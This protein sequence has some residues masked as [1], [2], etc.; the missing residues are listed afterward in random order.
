[1]ERPF[2]YSIF[3]T[4]TGEWN[5]Q[6]HAPLLHDLQTW[7]KTDDPNKRVLKQTKVCYIDTRYKAKLRLFRYWQKKNGIIETIYN[8]YAGAEIGKTIPILNF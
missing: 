5:Y 3:N 7:E 2:E 4:I 1:M 8:P 6:N